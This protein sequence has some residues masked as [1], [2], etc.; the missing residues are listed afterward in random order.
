MHPVWFADRQQAAVGVP[1]RWP[2]SLLATTSGLLNVAPPS[3]E[4]A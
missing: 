1:R 2:S 4:D 3:P